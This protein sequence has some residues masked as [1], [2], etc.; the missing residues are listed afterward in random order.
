MKKAFAIL[1]VMLLTISCVFCG[2]SKKKD[3]N[4]NNNAAGTEQSASQYIG[5]WKATK[6]EFKG[7]EVDISEVVETDF[8]VVLKED[9]TADV[10]SDDGESTAKWSETSKGLKVK[11]DNINL[12]LSPK[13]DMLVMELFGF[14]LYFEKQ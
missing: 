3:D 5:T 8:I 1:F 9:G 4:N 14:Y 2:C 11:G 7:E 10:S 12:D 13:D 6:A